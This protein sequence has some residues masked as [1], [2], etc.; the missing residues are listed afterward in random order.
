MLSIELILIIPDPIG[1]IKIGATIG[2]PSD[3]PPKLRGLITLA[4]SIK[5]KR[6]IPKGVYII[7]FPFAQ[8]FKDIIY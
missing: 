4:K 2:K 8:A 6:Q 3:R 1:E 5:L 7:Q